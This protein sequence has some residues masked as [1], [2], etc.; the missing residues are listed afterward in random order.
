MSINN[1]LFSVQN[2]SPAMLNVGAGKTQ[3]YTSLSELSSRW[4]DDSS[5]STDGLGNYGADSVSLTYKNIGNKMVNDMASVTAGVITQYPDLD[6]DY[7]IAI[8]D[9]GST[10]EARVYRRSEILDNFKGTDEEKK[11]LKAQLD[12]NPLM[13]FNSASGLPDSAEDAGSQQLAKKINE[14]L[15]TNA[16]SL[17]VLDKAGYDPLANM[18]GSSSMKK[19][20]A[21]YAQTLKEESS[22]TDKSTTDKTE[23]KQQSESSDESSEEEETEV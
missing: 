6:G 10:R 16:K 18:L 14:F 11:K 22:S 13:V 7:V 3:N 4:G 5:S 15:T 1:L 21:Y 12:E 23:E 2:M 9:D 19:I 20:L 17:N 8:V